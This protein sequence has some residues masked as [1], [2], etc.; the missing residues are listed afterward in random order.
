[1]GMLLVIITGGI[2]VSVG[3]MTAAVAIIS[4]YM[5]HA[6]GNLLTV[7]LLGCGS[8]AILGA[9]NGFFVAKLDIP[10]I[11]VTLGTMS[12]I[13]GGMLYYTGGSWITNIPKWFIDFGR[14]KLL[15]IPVQIL[16]LVGAAVLTHW[17]LRYTLIGR[18]VFAV[19]GNPIAAV[20]RG[21]IKTRFSLSLFLSWFYGG[22]L[23]FIPPSC[24][25][26]IPT[27][28]FPFEMTVIAAV[29]LGGANGWGRRP[30][31]WYHPWCH[32]AG[33]YSKRVDSSLIPTCGNL[34]VGAII[35]LAV[36]LDVMQNRRRQDQLTR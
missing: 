11:V 25:R 17:V 35:L 21:F 13:N 14:I 9:I 32:D 33:G 10:P 12:I 4:K 24:G 36:S 3:A 8:G 20:R 26:L 29:V 16:F 23:V 2:D 34:V 18:G 7:F 30:C 19:G 31:L 28:F 22:L 5:V 15:G 1:M 6:G 27:P